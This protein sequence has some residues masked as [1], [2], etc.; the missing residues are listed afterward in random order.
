MIHPAKALR[1][2]QLRKNIPLAIVGME[3]RLPIAANN[4]ER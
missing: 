2:R 3:D 4:D 1:S